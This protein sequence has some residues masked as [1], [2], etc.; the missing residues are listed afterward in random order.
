MSRIRRLWTETRWACSWSRAG[1]SGGR[2]HA[3]ACLLALN[4][5][6]ISEALDADIEHLGVVRGH[7]TLTVRRTGGAIVVLEGGNP[8]GDVLLLSLRFLPES[9]DRPLEVEVSMLIEFLF[10]NVDPLVEF[11]VPAFVAPSVR[12]GTGFPASS[13]RGGRF[14]DGG[15]GVD[16]ER[17]LP[18]SHLLREPAKDASDP[19]ESVK[20]ERDPDRCE[21]CSPVAENLGC[22]HR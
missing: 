9:P 18:S 19:L 21:D 14:D 16:R 6:R 20:R 8:V 1:I 2:D 12:P 13:R 3:L 4:G 11:V 5:L 7:R 15:F 22:W 17:I 10:D